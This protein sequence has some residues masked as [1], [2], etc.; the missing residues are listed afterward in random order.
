MTVAVAL[1]TSRDDAPCAV[2][3]YES[4]LPFGEVNVTGIAASNFEV[5]ALVAGSRA[6]HATQFEFAH[7]TDS[8]R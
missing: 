7:A 8:A 1:S 6:D 4:A 5:G 3:F 2:G